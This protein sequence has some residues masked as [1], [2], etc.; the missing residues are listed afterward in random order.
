[1]NLPIFILRIVISMLTSKVGE[2]LKNYRE[3]KKI[4]RED[5]ADQLG[6]TVSGYGKIERGK[7]DVPLT[8][9]EQ[10]SK[11]LG[12]SVPQIL[13]FDALQIFNISNNHL[14][15]GAGNKA[16]QILYHPDSYK[17]K[18]IEILERENER[19]RKALGEI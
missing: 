18:Y 11:V 19:L 3:L 8:R 10:I 2:S 9:L 12:V 16:E 14:V 1:M 4:T 5:M 17:D 6:M 15:Q 7:T 13:Q